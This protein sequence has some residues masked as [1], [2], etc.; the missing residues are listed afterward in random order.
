MHDVFDR[1]L[2]FPR[3]WTNRDWVVEAEEK[4]RDDIK[5]KNA[6][7]DG[8][9]VNG[10]VSSLPWKEYAGTYESE[11]YGKLEIREEE[12]SLRLQ[13]GPNIP[14]TLR[15]WEH[16]TFRGRLSFP[17]DDEWLVRLVLTDGKAARVEI[18]RLFWHEPMPAFR[19]VI[20]RLDE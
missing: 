19:H 8:K 20:A 4:P 15:H 14:A 10:T 11:L 17:P 6:Q 5:Q 1:L 3:T 9:R 12:G 18:E 7:L 13:F 2:G 16:D